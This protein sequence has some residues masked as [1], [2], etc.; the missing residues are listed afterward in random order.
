M[1]STR[2]LSSLV[3]LVLLASSAS[4]H[5]QFQKPTD[6]ELKMTADP[7][8]PDVAAVILN[9]EEKTD[10]TVHYTSTYKRIKILKDSA[11]ELATV[12]LGYFRGD[13]EI[14][15]IQGRT[16][17][18]DGSIT[19]LGVKPADLM[20]A[21]QGDSE[22][23]EVVFNLPA[24]ETGSIIEYYYQLRYAAKGGTGSGGLCSTPEWE[25]QGEYPVRK[26][27]YSFAP[28][29]GVLDETP[30]VGGGGV[31]D[32]H[33]QM[34]Y[35]LSWYTHL[36][37]GKALK[38]TIA[39]RFDLEFTDIPPLPNEAWMPPIESQR[40][41]VRFYY[42]AGNTPEA[43]WTQQAKFFLAD[44]NHFADP[45]GAIKSAAAGIVSPSDS[46]LD[47]AKKLYAAVQ[48]LDNTDFSRA[49]GK[50]ELRAEGFRVARR[51]EDTWNQKS[52]S[53]Q[54]IALLYL[55]LLRG[56]GLTAYPMKVVD[57]RY[58]TFNPN[59][60]NA[61]QLN[62]LVII[63]DS[64]G[65]EI[66]LDPAEK[67]CPF[68]LVSWRHSGAGGIRQTAAGAGPGITPLLPYSA[69]T[70]TRRATVMVAADGSISGKLNFTFTGQQALYWRQLALR[71]DENTVH[72]DFD[73]WLQTQVPAGTQAH[74]ESFSN[75]D[76]TSADLTAQATIT[77]TP[78]SVAGKRIL[79][80]AAFFSN[81]ETRNFT[82]EANRQLPVDMQYAAQVKDGVLYHLPA[83][84]T[85]EAA[86]AAANIPWPNHAVYV[87]KPAQSESGVNIGT[88]LT[89]AFTILD[90][91]EY[92]Q[93]RDFY[94]K[95]ATAT[96][97]QV[98]LTAGDAAKGN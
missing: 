51:A 2:V 62:A 18:P 58:N 65:K 27:H 69:N 93:L 24:V 23:H 16:I 86:P 63:L 30:G 5:A 48:A 31:M 66:V 43:Y 73:R 88:A 21:K 32:E 38:P 72:N 29:A 89:R 92:A 14:A 19:D 59:Y 7:Q 11:K 56:A 57:R 87:F 34:L 47:K 40:Y 12:P 41:E 75:L 49:K 17:H 15:A 52:G 44:V 98:V 79:L 1:R 50:A 33:G 96:Q 70:L 64:G 8:Y 6:Q 82:T 81:G 9:L 67:M 61:Y 76:N 78:G 55:A 13:E 46:E 28:C 45:S 53:G 97:Q 3:V 26:S 71:V 39:K 80:P 20:R 37:G 74:V 60:L 77:G 95:V 85:V 94:Q 83:G 10:D 91:S 54:D 84:Y 25:I 68:G 90:P 22:L 4:L 35:N 36:P 42:T